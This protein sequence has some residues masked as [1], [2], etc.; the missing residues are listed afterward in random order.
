[1]RLIELID[2]KIEKIQ[3]KTI[4]SLSIII[5]VGLAIRLYFTPWEFLQIHLIPLF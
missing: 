2:E 4:L 1:M 3:S 5:L